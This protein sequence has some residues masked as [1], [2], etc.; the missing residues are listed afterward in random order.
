MTYEAWFWGSTALTVK[1]D[2]SRAESDREPWALEG[3]LEGYG[4]G[5]S[6]KR[7]RLAA[8]SLS[9]TS[10]PPRR[11]ELTGKRKMLGQNNLQMAVF[12]DQRAYCAE[13]F[14]ML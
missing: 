9:S 4:K 5:D 7:R 8:A 14:P 12:G 1:N 6:G 2:S 11:G 13:G 3:F 10:P